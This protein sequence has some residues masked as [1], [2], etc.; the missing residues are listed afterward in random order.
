MQAARDPHVTRW[1]AL[2]PR[3]RAPSAQTNRVVKVT[4]A[5]ERGAR[6]LRRLGIAGPA[7]PQVPLRG[8]RR[9]E[10]RQ[11][12]LPGPPSC[13]RLER[14]PHPRRPLRRERLVRRQLRELLPCER[15]GRPQRPRAVARA[16][17]RRPGSPFVAHVA[18]ETSYVHGRTDRR[19]AREGQLLF[20]PHYYNNFYELTKAIASPRERARPARLRPA[21]HAAPALDRDR[22]LAHRQQRR[23]HQG[24]QRS[25][26]RVRP[27]A[28][29]ARREQAVRRVPS[30]RA[31][32]RSPRSPGAFPSDPLGVAQPDPGPSRRPWRCWRP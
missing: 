23:R 1:S 4:R 8:R 6:L 2:P 9:R 30:G 12:A 3:P 22:G 19:P 26:Q 16:C 15:A 20:P 17:R 11:L 21:P 13:R 7:R 5:R 29:G 18:M 25:R 24:D 27:F 10:A 28:A 14:T 32:W 31:A